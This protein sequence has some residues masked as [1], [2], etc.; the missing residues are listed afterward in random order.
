MFESLIPSRSAEDLA[1]GVIRVTLGGRDVLLEEV[2]MDAMDAWSASVDE[3]LNGL[4]GGLEQGQEVGDVMAALTAARPLV[5][6]ALTSYP[7]VPDAETLRRTA[8]HSEVLRAL[9][10]VWSAANPLVAVI[11]EALKV[12]ASQTMTGAGNGSALMST[13][14]RIS[15][16]RSDDSDG[17]SPTGNSSPDSTP[18]TSGSPSGTRRPSKPRGPG[19]STPTTARRT[20]TG[21]AA[22]GRARPALSADI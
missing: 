17:S 6:D 15:D 22:A 8:T 21:N 20:P 13:L 5:L 18:P 10:G 1:S 16:G 7:G 9:L 4:L 11:V 12:A 2:P 3:R 14:Q 19:S